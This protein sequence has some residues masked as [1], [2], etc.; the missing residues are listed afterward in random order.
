MIRGLFSS[1]SGLLVGMSRQDV[2]ANNLAN[3]QTPGYRQDEVALRSFPETLL[4]RFEANSPRGVPIG[5]IGQGADVAAVLTSDMPGRYVQTDNPLD[6]ALDGEAFF[7]VDTA[8]GVSYTRQ[9]RLHVDPAGYLSVATGDRLLDIDGGMI[10]LGD[11][12]QP[13]ISSDGRINN[14][15]VEV[16]QIGL[17]R[18]ADVAALRKQGNNYYAP[19]AALPSEGE[20][21]IR[22]GSV[23]LPN[24]DLVTAMT[25]M[26]AILR[27]YE[28][29]QKAMQAQD[30]TLGKA[31][32]EVGRV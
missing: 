29:S 32:N 11:N 1:A 26:I 9:G 31:V 28:A 5:T 12:A 22:Q 16:A 15:G 18:F 10:L 24:T 13:V 25:E 17:W 20:T 4:R 8:A 23:E 21:L 2:W 30:E 7:A 14:G 3:A 27:A 19:L 6:V